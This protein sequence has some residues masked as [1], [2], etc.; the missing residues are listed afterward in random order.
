MQFIPCVEPRRFEN[1]A[2]GE[3]GTAP[4]NAS[5]RETRTG[6]FTLGVTDWSVG[7]EDWGLFLSRIFDEW[8]AHDQGRVKVNLFETMLAQAQGL[9]ALICTSSPYC[10][11]NVAVEHDGRVY[12]CD[13]YVYPEYELGTIVEQSLGEMVFSLK[14]LEFGLDKYNSLPREC[15]SCRHLK[16]CWGECPRTR[17]LP[18]RPGEGRLSYLCRGW[19]RFFDHAVPRIPR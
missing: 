9:S 6:Q 11:K 5:D 13:H 1:T 14:Q 8:Q 4:G 18:T 12:A 16:L 10:G 2:A 15:R 17:I 3:P 19:K 7:A